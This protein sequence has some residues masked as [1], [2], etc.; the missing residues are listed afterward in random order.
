MLSMPV[1]CRLKQCHC[2]LHFNLSAFVKNLT[3]SNRTRSMLQR[4]YSPG[5]H[6]TAYYEEEITKNIEQV[7]HLQCCKILN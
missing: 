4:L 5:L 3:V 2:V 6:A 7:S 1:N